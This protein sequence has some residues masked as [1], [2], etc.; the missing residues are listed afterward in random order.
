MNNRRQ[1][2]A[3]SA[4]DADTLSKFE[5]SPAGQ[6][7]SSHLIS[8]VETNR[9]SRLFDNTLPLMMLCSI[10][11]LVPRSAFAQNLP[12]DEQKLASLE[13]D[14]LSPSQSVQSNR[15]LTP[16]SVAPT[17]PIP[18]MIRPSIENR[19]RL[20]VMNDN[21]VHS[22]IGSQTSANRIFSSDLY[23]ELV[24]APTASNRAADSNQ[25]ARPLLQTEVGEWCLPINLSSSTAIA[26]LGNRRIKGAE[27][28]LEDGRILADLEGE[29]VLPTRGAVEELL[30]HLVVARHPNLRINRERFSE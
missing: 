27:R 28:F 2:K 23:A 10:A 8:G 30:G 4:G 20:S 1:K 3:M 11:L 25:N 17:T 24:T 26:T 14:V 16:E 18:T 7:P 19:S 12:R 29:L 6:R 21:S 5:R 13:P 9:I 22:D 15:D